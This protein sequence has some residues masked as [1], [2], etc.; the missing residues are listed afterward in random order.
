MLNQLS[1]PGAHPL[2]F[3][4]RMFNLFPPLPQSCSHALD[5][6]P[7]HVS[8]TFIPTFSPQHPFE[9]GHLSEVSQVTQPILHINL[10]FLHNCLSQS[11]Q[12]LEAHFQCHPIYDILSSS[13]H[14]IHR[15]SSPLPE[16]AHIPFYMTHIFYLS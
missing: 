7:H 14:M 6:A 10:L 12:S 16:T 5:L 11:R 1:N 8:S 4:K 3:F 15:T 9:L 2:P 13:L